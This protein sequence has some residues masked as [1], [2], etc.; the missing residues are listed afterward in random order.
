MPF[1]IDQ[2]VAY[3]AFGL[4]RIAA[5][6][7]KSLLDSDRQDFYEVVGEH[8]TLWVE[9]TEASARGLR[10]LA[11]RVEL[12]QFRNVLRGQPAEL[13]ADARQRHKDTQTQLRRGTLQDLCEVVRDLSALSWRKALGE[14]DAVELKKAR[15]WLCQEWAA[16]DGV[17][18][19]KAT[20]EVNALLQE[21]R[22]VYG[23]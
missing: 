17:S 2:R 13:S 22:K 4:G 12:P 15:S 3:P 7:T 21:A 8:S 16:A 23:G 6:V 14:Y 19:A 18:L 1:Q 10:R 5:V 9:V 20:A 11:Q